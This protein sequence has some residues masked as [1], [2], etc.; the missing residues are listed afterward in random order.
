M[1]NSRSN[2]EGG[3]CPRVTCRLVGPTAPQSD[4]CGLCLQWLQTLLCFA[5]FLGGESACFPPWKLF[6]DLWPLGFLYLE[7]S[8]R[9][10]NAPLITLLLPS[11]PANQLLGEQALGLG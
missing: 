7:T 6:R 8:S 5:R 9:S 4:Q 3:T 11:S 10:R 1:P 2:G